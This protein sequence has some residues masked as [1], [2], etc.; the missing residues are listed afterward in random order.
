MSLH[1]SEV[2]PDLRDA[3]WKY[4]LE[5]ADTSLATVKGFCVGAAA[6]PTRPG[7]FVAATRSFSLALINARTGATEFQFPVSAQQAKNTYRRGLA[8]SP[9][10]ERLAAGSLG[11]G[12]LAIYDLRNGKPLLEWDGP[13]TDTLD[14]SND[15]ETLLQGSTIQQVVCLWDA[16]TGKKR[17]SFPGGGYASFD[18]TGKKVISAT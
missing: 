4:L 17:W 12:G 3:N 11:E 14:F 15:G 2:P 1:L 10:G 16:E 6:H 7:I 8:I 18:A 9:D 13:E 5:H